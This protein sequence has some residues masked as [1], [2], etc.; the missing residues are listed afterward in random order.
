M[1]LSQEEVTGF[2]PVLFKLIK[3]LVLALLENVVSEILVRLDEADLE[4]LFAQLLFSEHFDDLLLIVENGLVDG[5]HGVLIH[6]TFVLI[7]THLFLIIIKNESVI[8][9]SVH[10]ANKRIK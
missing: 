7:E 1:H 8:V 4:P 9:Q 10:F 6:Y 3:I 5:G 2:V